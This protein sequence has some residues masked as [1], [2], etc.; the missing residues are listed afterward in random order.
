MKKNHRWKDIS[1]ELEFYP[2]RQE[3]IK[4][5]IERLWIGGD[6]QGWEYTDFRLP[7]G[8]GR[9]SFYRPSCT[10]EL[11]EGVTCISKRNGEYI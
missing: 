9:T 11:P 6:Y 1:N 3:C 4:C 10:P 7:F 2:K 8:E 5:G